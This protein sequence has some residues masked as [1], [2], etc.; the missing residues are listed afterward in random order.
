MSAPFKMNDSIVGYITNLSKENKKNKFYLKFSMQSRNEQ[1]IDGWIFSNTSGILS[2]PLGNAL[3][4]SL[5]NHSG[6]RLWGTLEEDK[7]T[8]NNP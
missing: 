8:I 3:T 4:D 1:V 5:K 2:T 6:L 7:G